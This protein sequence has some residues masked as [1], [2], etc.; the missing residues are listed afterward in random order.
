MQQWFFK[1][2]FGGNMAKKK[3]SAKRAVKKTGPGAK[4]TTTGT[5][6][7]TSAASSRKARIAVK[8]AVRAKP[9]SKT[10]SRPQQ[11]KR[12]TKSSQ[13]THPPIGRPRISADEK[14]Y[15]LFKEDYHARQIF[16]FL[17]VE[18]LRDL[19]QHSPKEIFQRLT[20]PIQQTLTRTREKLA[21]YN[22][23]LLEDSDFLLDQVN[24]QE[25]TPVP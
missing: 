14:L 5:K 24:R 3:V 15:L 12:S 17:R 1:Q 10:T 21:N 9:K 16:E 19:E 2:N 8:S 7:G 20:A 4:R 6:R 25:K 18:T 11:P 23:C 13:P 22:R